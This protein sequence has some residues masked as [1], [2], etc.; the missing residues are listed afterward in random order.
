MRLT[1]GHHNPRRVR[2]TTIGTAVGLTA[3]LVGLATMSSASVAA[4]AQ[5]PTN[6]AEPA[7]TGTP[8]VGRIL[9]SSTGSW[10]GSQPITFTRQWVRC[11]ATGGLPDGSKCSRI[12][13]ATRT[14]YELRNADVGFRLRVRVT[15]ANSD[16]SATAA[17][18]PTV[19]IVSARPVNTDRLSISGSLQ[20][21]NRLQANR[22]TWTGEEP[23]TFSYRWQRCNTQG[24]NC[25]EISGAT[26]NDYVVQE[27]DVGR[28]LRVRVTARNDAGSSSALSKATGV[29]QPSG[30]SGVITLPSGERS[31]PATSV[32]SNERLIVSQVVF[33]PNPVTSRQSPITVRIRVTDTRGFVVRDA[34]VFIRAT[35]RVTS[36][37]NRQPTATDGWVTYQLVPNANFPQPR[38]GFNVQFFVKA[39]R[40]GDPPLAGIA[41]YR[42]VQVR[43]AG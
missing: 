31:I 5:A 33:S 30:P 13:G 12:S 17:S 1:R 38:N 32:P 28:T 36:G 26:D 43:L 10:T 24:D 25:S 16:G 19:G 15:A 14:T 21:G 4:P 23:M 9:T 8:M 40:A 3:L 6:T 39:Y 11:D 7:I 34:L 35:P 29:V 18:N 42:L 41:A 20:Q 2:P 37:G 22:G 27:R